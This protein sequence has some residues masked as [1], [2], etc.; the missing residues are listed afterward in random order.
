M[1]DL[2]RGSFRMG[3][4]AAATRAYVYTPVRAIFDQAAATLMSAAHDKGAKQGI[5]VVGE[6]S[7]GKT[8]LALE[9]LIATHPDWDALI[10]NAGD[11]ET[12]IPTAARLKGRNLAVFLDDVDRYAAGGAVSGDGDGRSAQAS[13]A[14]PALVLQTLFQRVC[15]DANHVVFVATCRREE[16]AAAEGSLGWLFQKLEKVE[17]P[18]FNRDENSPEAQAIIA[19]FKDTGVVRDEYNGTLGSLVLG[20]STKHQQYV[21]LVNRRSPAVPV[22]RAMKLLWLGGTRPR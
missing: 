7:A 22:L 3:D 10:W 20:M 15:Q 1:R 2:D 12:R 4:R 16:F 8:R 13:L 11:Q 18:T 5:L 19:E 9:A 17:V 6:G 21:E 14:G